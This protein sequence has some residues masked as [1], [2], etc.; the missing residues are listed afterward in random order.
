[1]QTHFAAC[2]LVAVC[3]CVT[4]CALYYMQSLHLI[5]LNVCEQCAFLSACLSVCQPC[6]WYWFVRLVAWY[7]SS[8][9][10][11]RW[12]LYL[13]ISRGLFI[14][15]HCMYVCVDVCISPILH[16]F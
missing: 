10:Q 5:S 8:Q 15:C 12:E 13:H 7:V 3:M 16:R 11:Y 1:M 9:T 14:M 2:F 4:V 6:Y